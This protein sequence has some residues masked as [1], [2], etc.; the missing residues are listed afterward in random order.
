MVQMF[1]LIINSY[2]TIEA[3]SLFEVV[4]GHDM[5]QRKHGKKA[6]ENLVAYCGLY[7]GECFA[8]K[9]MIADLARD[10]RKELRQ[11]RFDIMADA[12]SDISYFRVFKGYQT[13]DMCWERW[14]SSDAKGVVVKMAGI[15]VANFGHAAV[16]KN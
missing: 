14:S 7:C 6:A 15:P 9:G 10:I 4:G 5:V 13:C 16:K 1:S 8:H 11:T 12:M 2:Q 3:P